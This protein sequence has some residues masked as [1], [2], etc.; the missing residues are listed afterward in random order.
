MTVSE[1]NHTISNLEYT[2]LKLS[3]FAVKI[4]KTEPITALFHT[5]ATCS[6]LSQQICRMILDKINIIKKPL[7]VN[8]ASGTTLEQ[9]G[10]T[11]L[12]LKWNQNVVDNFIV[13]TKL[14]EHIILGLDLLRDIG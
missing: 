9:I 7:K 6:S 5:G 14:K 3:N 10:I 8:T 12:E 1:Q 2:K 13:F 11:P 4:L